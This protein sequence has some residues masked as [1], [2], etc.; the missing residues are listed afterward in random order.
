METALNGYRRLVEG[1]ANLTMQTA[2]E[3]LQTLLQWIRF[4]ERGCRPDILVV[5][6]IH[7]KEGMCGSG[8]GI[9]Y[10]SFEVNSKCNGL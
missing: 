1:A 9:V 4:A 8:K 2:F 3:F 5:V 10:D 7:L 6:N